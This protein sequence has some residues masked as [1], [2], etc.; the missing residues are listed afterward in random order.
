MQYAKDTIGI[1]PLIVTEE[2]KYNETRNIL[3]D[4]EFSLEVYSLNDNHFWNSLKIIYA[5]FFSYVDDDIRCRHCF[6]PYPNYPSY[7]FIYLKNIISRYYLD[8]D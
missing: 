8:E 3:K 4:M 1:E 5:P 2:G 6:I 7:S